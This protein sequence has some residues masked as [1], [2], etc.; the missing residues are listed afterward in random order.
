VRE[1][2]EAPTP[3]PPP[4][5]KPEPEPAPTEENPDHDPDDPVSWLRL[6]GK[7]AAEGRH[8]EA[9]ACRKTAMDL[10]QQDR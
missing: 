2:E 5:V 8:D 4:P 9:E 10:M 1:A 7:M 6:A 3:P